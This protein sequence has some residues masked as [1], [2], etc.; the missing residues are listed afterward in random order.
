MVFYFESSVTGYVVYMGKDKFENEGLIQWGWKSDLWFHV[1]NLSS[2]HVYLRVPLEQAM[3]G[4]EK[5]RCGCIMQGIPDEV[6]EEMCQL[7]K[8]NSIEGC[9]KASVTVVYTPHSNLHKDEE[10]MKTGAVGFH[11]TALRKLRL[12]E[13]DKGQVKRLEKTRREA[14][15]D[16]QKEKMD[17]DRKVIAWKKQ[18]RAAELAIKEAND[19]KRA[20]E[21]AKKAR[22]DFLAAG[23]YHANA[24]AEVEEDPLALRNRKRG[25]AGDAMSGLNNALA[26]LSSSRS[27]GSKTRGKAAVEEPVDENT[28]FEGL[29][30]QFSWELEAKLRADDNEDVKWLRERGYLAQV[31]SEAWLEANGKKMKALAVLEPRD[32][33]APGNH[34]TMKDAAQQRAEER[35]ALEA[36]FED[37]ARLDKGDSI[38][39]PVTGFQA[40]PGAPPLQLEVHIDTQ[41]LSYPLGGLPLL[42][43][44]GGGLLESELL[45]VTKSLVAHAAANVSMGQLVFELATVAGEKATQVAEARANK[46]DE[47][48]QELRKTA[49]AKRAENKGQPKA[50]EGSG[51]ATAAAGGGRGSS[52]MA[53]AQARLGA[54]GT[55]PAIT[56]VTAGKPSARVEKEAPLDLD[57]LMGT[58]QVDK[59]GY[60]KKKKK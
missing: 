59:G 37:M 50:S 41:A 52:R 33:M 46:M 53:D 56:A 3:C 44:V 9:K 47:R 10:S 19:P 14:H 32:E 58:V 13:K 30:D 42:A 28:L 55:G 43:V 16:L 11:S 49:A 48:K 20:E 7:V 24:H 57:D 8:A 25:G 27:S 39:V 34:E 4:C 6:V 54:F 40:E 17:F 15:P 29:M 5:A 36:I 60:K 35:E 2:A 12:V 21:A 45:E 1:D 31:A 26:S 18:K 51:S 23:G 38:R 22:D